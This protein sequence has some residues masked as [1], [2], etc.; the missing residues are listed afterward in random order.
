MVCEGHTP[1][2]YLLKG[3]SY[4]AVESEDG[5]VGDSYVRTVQRRGGRSGKDEYSIPTNEGKDNAFG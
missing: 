4:E 1:T 5:S 2:Y 3:V